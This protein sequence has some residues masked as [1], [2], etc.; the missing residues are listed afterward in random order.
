MR[1]P[2]PPRALGAL[3]A[4]DLC[5]FALALAL[6]ATGCA[7]S[8]PAVPDGWIDRI[9]GGVAVVVVDHGGRYGEAV[10]PLDRLPPGASE[11]DVL[12]GGR[13]DRLA[14]DALRERVEGLQRHL[15]RRPPGSDD[16]PVLDL[17]QRE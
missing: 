10:V 17:R 15:R 6:A 1:A 9:E 14:R 11:G 4:R 2:L 8:E 12:R 16:A 3:A 13:L 7:A 5:A